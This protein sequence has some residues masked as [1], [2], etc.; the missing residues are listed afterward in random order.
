MTCVHSFD[1]KEAVW[2]IT[3]F[4]I[5]E[6]HLVD[7]AL[8]DND[9]VLLAELKCTHAGVQ[10]AGAIMYEEAF[11]ATAILIVVLHFVLRNTETN[12]NVL[13]SKQH[14]PPSD[15]IA[16]GFHIHGFQMSHSH[17]FSFNEFGFR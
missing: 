3:F 17:G 7:Y 6:D 9:V 15:W 5:V 14:H 12:F 1:A 16:L 4:G 2:R 10:R 11:I 8:G 13:I